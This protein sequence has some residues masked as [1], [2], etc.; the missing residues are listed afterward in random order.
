[1]RKRD[2]KKMLK[3][4]KTLRRPDILEEHGN[5]LDGATRAAQGQHNQHNHYNVVSMLAGAVIF[6]ELWT[7]MA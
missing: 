5:D 2:W 6:R 3:Q 4:K 7:Y 1:M